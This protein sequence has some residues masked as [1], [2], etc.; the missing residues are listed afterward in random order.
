M[1][2][3]SIL[4]L[5]VFVM[6]GCASRRETTTVVYVMDDL[7]STVNYSAPFRLF[8]HDMTEE[9]KGKKSLESY[10]PSEE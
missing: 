1:R 3:I 9:M 10:V 8:W 5:I 4:I 7:P 6:L 2:Q